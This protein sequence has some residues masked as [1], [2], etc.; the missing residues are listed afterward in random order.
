MRTVFF[1]GPQEGATPPVDY[2][3]PTPLS[4]AELRVLGCL[5]EK[6]F[7]T[8]DIYPLTLNSLVTACNQKTSREP[9]VS[10]D[11]LTVDAVLATLQRRGLTAKITGADHRVPKFK[12]LLM[13]KSGLKVSE[14]GVLCV[15]MLRGPQTVN[16]LKD[17]ANRIHA[18]ASQAEVEE[19]LDRLIGREPQPLAVRLPRAPGQKEARYMH[20]LAGPVEVEETAI[21]PAPAPARE[22]RLGR[23]EAEVVGLKEQLRRIE[24]EWKEFRK[25]F[26]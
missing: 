26:E 9:V 16:E 4:A 7:F 21:A 12:E 23:L 10:Y 14:I 13:E 6:S 22:D 3:I 17:R 18:F 5:I 19:T 24:E 1:G 8:P 20:L 11:D 25:Q 2:L 15:M